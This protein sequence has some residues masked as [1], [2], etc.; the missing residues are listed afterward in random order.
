MSDIVKKIKEMEES[1]DQFDDHLKSITEALS[2]EIW[3]NAVKKKTVLVRTVQVRQCQNRFRIDWCR[4]K[5]IK[6][7]SH[8]KSK[9]YFSRI[10]LN[11]CSSRKTFKQSQI[12]MGKLDEFHLGLFI[13]YDK[14][15]AA[16]RELAEENGDYREGLKKMK[17]IF[18]GIEI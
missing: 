9:V 1:L 7:D 5:H 14:K 2:Q 15:F 16:I 13:E 3:R 11:K 10:T 6:S 4:L 8:T 12:L 17:R 18:E